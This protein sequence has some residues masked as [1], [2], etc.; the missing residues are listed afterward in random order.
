MT[1]EHLTELTRRTDPHT[2]IVYI[3]YQQSYPDRIGYSIAVSDALGHRSFAEDLTDDR[4]A[5]ERFL[6][7]LSEEAAEPCHL[8][9]FIEDALPLR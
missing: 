9:D 2:F 5:A 8:L 1:H 4:D 7:L 3:L 6:Q